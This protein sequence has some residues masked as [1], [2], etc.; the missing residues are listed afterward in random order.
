MSKILTVKN[1]SV[2]F[3][4]HAVIHEL[5]FELD[6]GES[7]AI[8]GPNGAGKTM[9]LRALLG[10]QQ[11]E[12]KII[13][14]PNTRV[15]YVPQKIEADRHLPINLRNLL[16]AKAEVISLKNPP[17]NSA[18]E[19]VG[20]AR[21]SLETQIGHL[22]GGQFQRALIAFAL[23]GSPS[24]LLFDEPT[25]SIDQQ[26]ELQIYDL[27]HELQDNRGITVI[28]VSH[29]ISFVNRHATKVLC[30]NREKLCFGTPEEALTPEVLGKLYG[31]HHRYFHH[32][33]PHI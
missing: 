3:D 31:D 22:S 23:L 16:Y 13:W 28:L 26:G 8:I 29:D 25:A 27:I 19:E 2:K 33:H 24:V 20:L 9:L 32:I 11:Y 6:K 17:I 4:R 30:I 14:A 1:L 21:T 5:S 12:G 10:T 7:L 18:I 15:G